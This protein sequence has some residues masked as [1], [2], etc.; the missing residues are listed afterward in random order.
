MDERKWTLSHSFTQGK[1]RDASL[2][3]DSFLADLRFAVIDGATDKSGFKYQLQDGSLVS[4][5]KFA[6]SIIR[7]SISKIPVGTSVDESVA[8]ISNDLN[9]AI[10]AQY[11]TI[12]IEQRPS[13]SLV[14]FDPVL[15]KIFAVG[16]CLYGF[17]YNDGEVIE[18]AHHFD[19]D[20]FLH[21]IRK[22]VITARQSTEN[23]WNPQSNEPDPGREVIMPIL[24][25]Q[26]LWANSDEPFGYGV[27]NGLPVPS[28]YIRTQ[29]VSQSC[30]EIVLASDGYPH[31][32]VDHTI[33]FEQS[34]K[35]L[36]HLLAIDPLCLDELKGNKGLVKDNLAHDDRTWLQ[37]SRTE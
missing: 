29:R 28:K 15:E 14:V 26:G 30:R 18:F 21:A 25:I 23:P 32:I 19:I 7:E 37:I 35:N 4:A 8:T 11:P 1:N 10:L 34:E 20:T 9:D 36:T 17:I 5:G 22:K 27:I 3:E 12:A 16:D 6:S 13:A 31:L 24:K 2:S 33:N